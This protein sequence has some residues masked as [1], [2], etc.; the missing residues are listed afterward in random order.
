MCPSGGGPCATRRIRQEGRNIYTEVP[1]PLLVF[2][3]EFGELLVQPLLTQ[4]RIGGAHCV[5]GHG[6]S[7]EKNRAWEWSAA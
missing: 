5:D 1:A 4:V 6:H 7:F 2:L 3:I